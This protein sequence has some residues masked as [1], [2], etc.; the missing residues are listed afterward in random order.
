MHCI[1]RLMNL[2]MINAIPNCVIYN[3]LLHVESENDVKTSHLERYSR[4]VVTDAVVVVIVSKRIVSHTHS[5]E[6]YLIFC[7]K[8]HT[9]F[10]TSSH[11]IAF[12]K[13]LWL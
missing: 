12:E 13:W 2:T 9:F 4:T 3:V 1:C 11:W 7:D 5:S 8:N 10:L 6:S